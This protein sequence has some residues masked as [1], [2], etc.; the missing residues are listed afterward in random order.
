MLAF[1]YKYAIIMSMFE[2]KLALDWVNNQTV[3]LLYL[4]ISHTLIDIFIAL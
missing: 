3:E 1:S 4:F 2:Q